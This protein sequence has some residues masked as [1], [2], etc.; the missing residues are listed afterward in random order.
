LIFSDASGGAENDS[1]PTL[2]YWCAIE[3]PSR[4]QTFPN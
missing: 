4:F 1:D 3:A 2:Y